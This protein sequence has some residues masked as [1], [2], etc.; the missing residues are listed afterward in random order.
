[1][2]ESREVGRPCLYTPEMQEKAYK[3][4]REFKFAHIEGC[5]PA[6]VPTVAGMSLFLGV[7][8]DSLYEWESRFPEFSDTLGHL[9]SIQE[10]E[11]INNGLTG[12]F[13][14]PIAKILL[15][16]HGY[17]DKVDVENDHS[18]KDGTMTPQGGVIV[19]PQKDYIKTEPVKEKQPAHD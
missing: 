15:A 12:D 11:L 1:M 3:Y 8:R 13:K 16:S 7:S 5:T 2:T 14:S 19:L 17:A 6:V 18:S 9:R 10:N 4:L